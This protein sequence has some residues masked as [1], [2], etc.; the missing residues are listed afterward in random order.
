MDDP[1]VLPVTNSDADSTLPAAPTRS[2][3]GSGMVKEEKDP[4]SMDS[5]VAADNDVRLRS[6]ER[7]M[8]SFSAEGGCIRRVVGGRFLR[9]NSEAAPLLFV[10]RTEMPNWKPVEGAR[11]AAAAVDRKAVFMV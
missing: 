10:L 1:T 3:S 7:I 8:A 6:D 4:S 11:H 5:K 2:A 9:D